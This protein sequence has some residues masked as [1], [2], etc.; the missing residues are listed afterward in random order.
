MSQPAICPGVAACPMP[1]LLPCANAGALAASSTAIASV[2]ADLDI[3]NLAVRLE[4]PGLDAVI[5]IDRVDAADL[6]QRVL[7]R[8]HIAGLVDRARLQQQRLAAPLMLEVKPR[9]RLAQ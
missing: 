4:M 1:S 3:L 7:G 5:V 8:L 9:A 2:L 6:A